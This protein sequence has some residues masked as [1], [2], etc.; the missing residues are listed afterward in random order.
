M[1]SMK[2][3]RNMCLNIHGTVMKV[4]RGEELTHEER[5]RIVQF[6]LETV[7]VVGSVPLTE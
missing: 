7:S 1:E 5:E 6:Y 4:K 3:L 2:G